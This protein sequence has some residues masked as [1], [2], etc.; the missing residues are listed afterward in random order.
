MLSRTPK[1]AGRNELTG[2]EV[3]SPAEL[4]AAIAKFSDLDWN[5]I[6]KTAL[7]FRNRVGGDWEDLKN[8]AFL[9]ALEFP[10]KRKCPKDVPVVTFLQNVIRSIASHSDRPDGHSPLSDELEAQK[11]TAANAV[12]P[13]YKARYS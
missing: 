8:D 10:P 6:E 9:L 1:S 11:E 13:G 2:D 5:R 4:S 3:L 7:Y 12:K